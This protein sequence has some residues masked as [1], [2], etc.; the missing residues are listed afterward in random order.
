MCGV[1]RKTVYARFD[2]LGF[3]KDFDGR[4]RLTDE[5]ESAFLAQYA[6]TVKSD[7]Q[8]ETQAETVTDAVTMLREQIEDLRAQVDSL[9]GQLA[10]KDTQIESLNDSLREVMGNL[11][12]TTKALESAQREVEQAHALHA[13]N[14]GLI[15]AP[16]MPA[17]SR[18]AP[19]TVQSEPQQP[20]E[21]SK[22]FWARL[23]DVFK[24]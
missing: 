17:E 14:Q 11:T 10:V 5:Q 9:T 15:K 13:A 3:E 6:K 4:Y 23:M 20:A 7:S 8:E 1:S 12:S 16:D 18:E 24:Q 22:G 21:T 19:Q 2:K